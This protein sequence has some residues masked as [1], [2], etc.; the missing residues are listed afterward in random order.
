M[1][2]QVREAAES[3]AP[4]V[5]AQCCGSYRRGKATCGDVDVLVTHPDGKSHK[6]LFSK[7]LARLKESGKYCSSVYVIHIGVVEVLP[8]LTRIRRKIQVLNFFLWFVHT[9]VWFLHMPRKVIS[10]GYILHVYKN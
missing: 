8:L 10:R 9:D 2:S 5:I 6:G 3:L 1:Q 7:L 4:G